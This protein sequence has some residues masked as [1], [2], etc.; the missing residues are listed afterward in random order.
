MKI[1]H[2]IKT[3]KN[4]YINFTNSKSISDLYRYENDTPDGIKFKKTYE[5]L[6]LF[7][8]FYKPIMRNLLTVSDNKENKNTFLP[9]LG[10]FENDS[11]ASKNWQEYDSEQYKEGNNGL[12]SYYLKFFNGPKSGNRHL[13]VHGG[14][15]YDTYD[16][17]SLRLNTRPD[18]K[19]HDN[20]SSL[21]LLNSYFSKNDMD[22]IIKSNFG[23]N[24]TAPYPILHNR[25][26]S[27]IDIIR[28][29]LGIVFHDIGIKYSSIDI[30]PSDSNE[31]SVYIASPY[32]NEI[33]KYCSVNSAENFDGSFGR[34]SPLLSFLFNELLVMFRYA[35][36]I[37]YEDEELEAF[38]DENTGSS[39]PLPN[40]NLVFYKRDKKMRFKSIMS[41]RID[42]ISKQIKSL[43]KLH[44]D[45]NY[46][47]NQKQF[48][49]AHKVLKNEIKLFESKYKAWFKD[50]ESKIVS[51]E[52]KDYIIE[53][54]EEKI[55]KL[56]EKK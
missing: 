3:S 52:Q 24:V 48:D 30:F 15:S 47:F 12:D 45:V 41:N 22:W 53:K 5:R 37:N 36:N 16:S 51:K 10:F 40:I 20:F 29:F 28:N 25:V 8:Q 35:D 17:W 34:S 32:A 1:V 44:N 19:D 23:K 9:F 43:N 55:R 4:E 27:F 13:L 7:L 46:S 21:N 38:L 11:I 18:A 49:H 56:E 14:H 42:R 31:L 2:K 26:V 33:N 6:S 50:K 54:L 39:I